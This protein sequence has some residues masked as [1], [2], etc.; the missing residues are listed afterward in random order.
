MTAEEEFTICIHGKDG[1]YF[2][3]IKRGQVSD[4]VRFISLVVATEQMI[5]I[6]ADLVAVID[7]DDLEEIMGIGSTLRHQGIYMPNT[8]ALNTVLM[9]KRPTEPPVYYG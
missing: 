2:Y 9:K 8:N 5:E 7:P 6:A 4:D 1:R 3:N